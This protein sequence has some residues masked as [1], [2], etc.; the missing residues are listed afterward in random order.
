[1][2]MFRP[3]SVEPSLGHDFYLLDYISLS[4]I[5]KCSYRGEKK[6]AKMYKIIVHIGSVIEKLVS[7][8]SESQICDSPYIIMIYR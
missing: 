8:A 5:S 4:G 1:M 7:W 2:I 6:S 3:N